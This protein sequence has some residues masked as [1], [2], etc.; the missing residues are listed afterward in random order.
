VLDTEVQFLVRLGYLV[1]RRLLWLDV[2]G[3]RYRSVLVELH[4]GVAF[5]F[6]TDLSGVGLRTELHL[7]LAR[8]REY[9]DFCFCFFFSF[10]FRFRAPGHGIA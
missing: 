1:C 7:L 4:P 5:H 10:S 2:T 3:E 8:V 6:S 9:V